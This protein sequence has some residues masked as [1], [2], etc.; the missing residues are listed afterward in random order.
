MRYLKKL[1]QDLMKAIPGTT[2][3]ASISSMIELQQRISAAYIRLEEN[4]K[5][6]GL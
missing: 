5:D 3:Y 4:L 1:R 2:E 6:D